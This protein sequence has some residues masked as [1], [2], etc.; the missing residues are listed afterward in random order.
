MEKK[1]GFKTK[2]REGGI[3]IFENKVLWKILGLIKEGETCRIKYNRAIRKSFRAPAI[4][5]KG[6]T[7][8]TRYIIRREQSSTLGR[9]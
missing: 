3:I 4:L 1:T 2:I 8:K 6:R 5:A 9:G 7:R